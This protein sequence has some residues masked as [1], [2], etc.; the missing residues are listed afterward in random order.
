[1]EKKK[2]SRIKRIRKSI[3][4][5]FKESKWSFF[6]ILIWFLLGFIFF[7]ATEY[8]DPEITIGD[9]LFYTFYIRE[10][11]STGTD[12][13][14]IIYQFLGTV[15]ISQGVFAFIVQKSFEKRDTKITSRLIA[16]DIKQNHIVIIHHGHVGS[17]ITDFF[18]ENNQDYVLIEKDKALVT[19]LLEDGEPVIVGNPIAEN[20][21][22]DANISTARAIII[23]ENEAK[24]TL[25]LINRIRKLNP[26]CQVFVRIFDDRLGAILE[27]RPYFATSFSTSRST[28]SRMKSEWIDMKK[29][30]VLVIGI[31]NF[32]KVLVEQLMISKREVVVVDER[33][34]EVDYYKGTDVKAIEGDPTQMDFLESP[35]IDIKSAVQV[36]VGIKE[37]AED[38][39]SVATQIKY[40]YPNIKVLM[41]LFSDDLADF[42]EQIGIDTFSTSKYTFKT[43]KPKLE[44][45]LL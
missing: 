36:F 21:L 34:N 45:L 41:R 17:R 4:L 38:S 44:S 13:A 30:K 1:M 5:Y 37:A 10:P 3:L 33:E 31:S 7:M 24:T 26:D 20:V 2:S 9:I 23:T 28:I 42:L 6:I 32:T 25:I 12:S 18:R 8:S 40:H 22:E 39:I 29:G 19:D 11:E 27:R 15:I 14:T 35:Q 43:L 16:K